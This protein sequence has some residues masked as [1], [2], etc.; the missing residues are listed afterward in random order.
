[1][2]KW[3]SVEDKLPE[4]IWVD[5]LA[6]KHS[7]NI[8]VVRYFGGHDDCGYFSDGNCYGEAK[9]LGITHWMT[10]PMPPVEKEINDDK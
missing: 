10:L 3:I 4:T 7:G 6:Y 5:V 2:N 9:D 8:Q 1:M